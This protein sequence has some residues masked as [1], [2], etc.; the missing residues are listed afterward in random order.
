MDRE[1]KPDSLES[2]L[3]YL[4]DLPFEDLDALESCNYLQEITAALFITGFLRLLP[5]YIGFPYSH[6]RPLFLVGEKLN[7][8]GPLNLVSTERC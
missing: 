2:P 6:L 7:H 8:L 3:L 5:A 4:F 1:G